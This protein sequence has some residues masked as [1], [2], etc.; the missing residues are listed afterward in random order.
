MSKAFKKMVFEK[1]INDDSLAKIDENNSMF[2]DLD[3]TE[4]KSLYRAMLEKEPQ[5]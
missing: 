3:E 1:R 2:E 4:I 5:L